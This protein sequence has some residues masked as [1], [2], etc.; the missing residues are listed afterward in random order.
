V[1]GSSQVPPP[2]AARIDVDPPIRAAADVVLRFTEIW[3]Q[4]L[5]FAGRSE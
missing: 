5:V 1:A 4:R 2:R 3:E